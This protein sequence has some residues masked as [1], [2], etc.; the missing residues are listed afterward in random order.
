MKLGDLRRKYEFR[1]EVLDI[2]IGGRSSID[3]NQGFSLSDIEDVD[4]FLRSYGYNLEDPIERAEAFGNFHEALAFIRRYFLQPENPEGIKIEI[5]RKILEMTDI[6]E[7][8]LAASMKA[9]GQQSDAQGQLLR[10]WC[11]SILKVMHTIAHMDQDIRA[12]YYPEIQ[13][14][15]FDR[16]YRVIQR[17]DE[18]SLYLGERMDDPL[19][20]NLSRFETKPKKARDSILLKMLHKQEN[21]AEE[22]FDRVGIR[23]VT[24]TRLGALRVIKFLKDRRIVLPPNIKPSRSRN[25]LVDVE[26]LRGTVEEIFAG[27]EDTIELNEEEIVAQLQAAAN[28]T[29]VGVNP[30]SS[31]HY[32]AIQFTARQL[33]KIRNPVFDELKE[34]KSILKA[35]D[36]VDPDLSKVIERVDLKFLQRD[37]HFFY[38]YEVQVVDE[39][40]H[41]ENE[42]GRG[43]HSEY[44]KAQIQ[45]AMKRV[46]GPLAP[47][48]TGSGSSSGSG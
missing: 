22:V 8:F 18:G 1:W 33:V 10:N 29:S 6:R 15:I 7:L 31:E 9:T 25:T 27:K 14:Q 43:A 20:V 30:H 19:R 13:K 47:P 11:C 2:I 40:S 38:P 39:K 41:E 23:F 24:R 44:K 4:R 28:G 21:V 32:R 26:Q 12:P 5:P 48:I 37:L 35:K 46:M 45:T 34:L 42:Q 36:S 17:D 16:F 3:S